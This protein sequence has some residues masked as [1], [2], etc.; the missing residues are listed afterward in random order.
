MT[1]AVTLTGAVLF[2][3]TVAG[4][5]QADELPRVVSLDYCADQYVLA[6]ADPAQVLALSLEATHVHSFYRGR[7]KGLPVTRADAE[8]VLALGPDL[9]IRNWGGD[10]RMI[11]LLGRAGI[12][13]M[14]AAYGS[15]PDVMF[16]N[17][18]RFAGAMG[19]TEEA[20]ALIVRTRANLEAVTGAPRLGLTAAYVA[21]GGITAGAGTFVDE[22]IDAVGFETSAS[23]FGL[24]GWRPLPLEV[25]VADPPDVIIAS[26]FDLKQARASN[27]SVA[28]HARVREMLETTP[29][30]YVPGRYFSCNGLFF[31]DTVALIRS[32]AARAGLVAAPTRDAVRE[33]GP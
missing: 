32:E 14:T 26:F 10:P 19:R 18:R 17:L 16:A 3:L 6:V 27:W 13:V 4:P 7:A 9:V 24:E 23:K 15:G 12:K 20:E 29:T 11:S 2:V 21:P 8:S 1:R 31:A 30:I 22:I 28:R 5:A 25:L 33:A